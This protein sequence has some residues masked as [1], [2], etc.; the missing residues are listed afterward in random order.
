MVNVT[1]GPRRGYR[2]Q[3][4]GMKFRNAIQVSVPYNKQ[5]IPPGMTEDDIRTFYFDDQAGHWKEL[6][7]VAVDASAMKIV[8]LTDHFTDI[9][10]ATVAVPDHPQPP[11]LNP[12]E[13]QDLQGADPG[14]GNERPQPPRA[15]AL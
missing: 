2:L 4:H 15:K 12:T 10:N 3:P 9:I 8:S 6:D 7:R 1:R 14:A 5:L 13:I 11:S